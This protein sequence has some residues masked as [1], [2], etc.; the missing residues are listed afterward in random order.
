MMFKIESFNLVK[1]TR[2]KSVKKKIIKKIQKDKAKK[3]KKDKLHELKEKLKAAAN[4]GMSKLEYQQNLLDPKFRAAMLGFGGFSQSGMSNANQYLQEHRDKNNELTRKIA[5]EEER[6]KLKQD[7]ERLNRELKQNKQQ[8]AD[9]LSKLRMEQQ[10]ESLEKETKRQETVFKEKVDY[11]KTIAAQKAIIQTLKEKEEDQKRREQTEKSIFDNQEAIKTAI[12]NLT[13]GKDNAKTAE[14]LREIGEQLTAITTKQTELQTQYDNTQKILTTKHQL[15]IAQSN[16]ETNDQLRPMEAELNKKIREAEKA[17]LEYESNEKY[18]HLQFEKSMAE[19]KADFAQRENALTQGI[20]ALEQKQKKFD[21]ETKKIKEYYDLISKYNTLSAQYMADRTNKNL[22]LQVAD[23][24]RQ[25]ER[26]REDIKQE[27]QYNDLLL[28]RDL[29]LVQV[30][31]ELKQAAFEHK[32]DNAVKIET[33]RKGNK[34]MKKVSDETEKIDDLTL[35]MISLGKQIFGE[36]W[37]HNEMFKPDF[38]KKIKT[39]LLETQQEAQKAQK[40]KDE[41]IQIRKTLDDTKK[42]QMENE[43]REFE[44]NDV[45]M[46]N[47]GMIQAQAKKHE[48]EVRQKAYNEELKKKNEVLENL[49]REHEEGTRLASQAFYQLMDMDP[50]FKIAADTVAQAKGYATPDFSLLYDIQEHMKKTGNDTIVLEKLYKQIADYQK[51]QGDNINYVQNLNEYVAGIT[52]EKDDALKKNTE[53]QGKLNQAY[54]YGWNITGKLNDRPAANL[55]AQ[56]A[57]VPEWETETFLEEV[58]NGSKRNEEQLEEKEHQEMM[59][60]GEEI[61]GYD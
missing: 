57:G 10:K 60:E 37:D 25:L 23:L 56:L 12:T 55:A 24:K 7:N 52:K 41:L 43:Q 44:N 18:L 29:L 50:N 38:D 30:D 33:V 3:K 36:K 54:A 8:H 16:E 26:F 28:E 2:K 61:F 32:A 59:R 5:V 20:A 9:E 22:E 6:A 45:E 17:K 11:E 53:L 42:I 27:N 14:K 13:V 1:M 48:E 47:K 39:K 21:L 34:L 19:Y 15:T 58:Y 51:E 46:R 4:G 49:K 31:P 35:N 40:K